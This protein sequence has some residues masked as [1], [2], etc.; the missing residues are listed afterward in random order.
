M[1]MPMGISISEWLPFPVSG[2]IQYRDNHM[3]AGEATQLRD[4]RCG[5]NAMETV[6]KVSP[7]SDVT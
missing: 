7:Y 1:S 5:Y 2:D 3:A 6:D 4:F